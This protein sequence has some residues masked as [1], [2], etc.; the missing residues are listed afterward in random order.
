MPILTPQLAGNA[1]F[2]LDAFSNLSPSDFPVVSDAG[3]LSTSEG[4]H[5][6]QLGAL[7]MGQRVIT[8]LLGK[9]TGIPTLAGQLTTQLRFLG[10]PPATL[11]DSPLVG[12][13]LG[14][15]A[16]GQGFDGALKATLELVSKV[17][18]DALQGAVGAAA[19]I[20]G[21][22]P[23]AGWVV[24]IVK[25]A[26]QL[27]MVINDALSP[28]DW[29]AL[30]VARP[31]Y[32]PGEDYNATS[33]ATRASATRDWTGLFSP[34]PADYTLATTGGFTFGPVGMSKYPN[35]AG[36]KTEEKG[37]WIFAQWGG[38]KDG[39]FFVQPNTSA[40]WGFVPTWEGRG[41]RLWRGCLVD[42]DK[43]TE[44][45]GN[46]IPTA[47]SAGLAMWRAVQN[48]YAPQIFFVDARAIGNRWLNYLVLL[49]KALHM[50]HEKAAFQALKDLKGEVYGEGT[51]QHRLW[52][53]LA[54]IDDGNLKK[55]IDRRRAIVNALVPVFG[56]APWGGSDEEKCVA[57]YDDIV[58]RSSAEYIER[59]KLN[60]ATP[61]VAAR[62]LF[63]RQVQA[64]QSVSV[65]YSREDDPCF[66][67][68]A[69]M[70]ELRRASINQALVT[71]R[72]IGL[73]DRDM[74]QENLI[75]Q[76]ATQLEQAA[77]TQEAVSR[78]RKSATYEIPAVWTG[79]EA[80][81]AKWTGQDPGAGGGGGLILGVA[82]LGLAALLLG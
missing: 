77:G 27:G 46:M 57:K 59:Y 62:E 34:A 20:A 64:T 36:R 25:A 26:V 73:V 54:T 2:D 8:T 17:G 12:E 82:G 50:S 81:P 33:I 45:V 24:E 38:N 53:S 28:K 7:D 23:I 55:K 31:V 56:W 42:K 74:I 65:L 43:R 58:L 51:V 41:G 4:W 60:D 44:L 80:A 10:V 22:F 52:L 5:V 75:A 15:V 76:Q 35:F 68:D 6:E 1:G 9:N 71:R 40:H 37:E 49:R 3:S 11:D 21:S 14:K 29:K 30:K 66:A 39:W 16:A 78:A 48:P 13:F 67:N 72:K 32:D 47:Q 19:N 79:A 63:N 70:R 18:F 69:A 61:V